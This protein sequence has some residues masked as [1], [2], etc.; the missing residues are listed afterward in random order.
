MHLESANSRGSSR[1]RIAIA[2]SGLGHISRGVETWAAD[3][4]TALHRAG[5]D[6]TLFQ[7]GGKAVAPWQVVVPCVHRFA[8]EAAR[9]TQRFARVGGW[10]FGMGQGYQV[11]QTTFGWSLWPL[12]RSGYDLVHTQ[13]SL[14]GLMLER[15]YRARLSRPRV[16]LAHGTEEPLR[17]LRKYSYLQHLAPCYRDDYEPHRPARQK[18]FAVG[19]FVNTALFRPG[20]RAAARAAWELPQDRLIVLCVAA[21]KRHHKRIDY[22]IDEFAAF[23]RAASTPATLVVAGGAEADTPELIDYGRRLLGDDVL[24]LEGIPRSQM[25]D[26]FRAADMF[27]LASL[28]EMMPIAVLEAIASGLPVICSDTPTFRWMAGPAG[29]LADLSDE[30]ALAEQLARLCDDGL[31]RRLG[32]AAREHAESCFSEPV[33]L[34]QIFDMYD[35]VLQ[36][37][38]RTRREAIAGHA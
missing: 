14:V 29:L 37:A 34:Q 31:R 27:A 2:C 9:L 10:R 21:I 33:I 26:L 30:G 18:S 22:L 15:L 8:P 28:T 36:G 38:G 6:V 35:T 11:E 3:L 20:D 24:F 7:G 4:A 32:C 19:N 5:A 1:P 16:I 12:V 17:M 13:D 23:R 25:P